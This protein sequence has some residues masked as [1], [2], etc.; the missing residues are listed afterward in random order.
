MRKI[1]PINEKPSITTCIH[2][3]YPCAII[4][5]KMLA[6]ISVSQF[7]KSEW[8]ILTRDTSV[9]VEADHIIVYEN[10]KGDDTNTV[11]WRH[12][13][14]CDECIVNMEYVKPKDIGRY[15][16]V[17]LFDDNMENEIRLKDKT[18]GIRWNPYGYFVVE[19]MYNFD[20]KIYTFL[21]IC[22]N[23]KQ[24]K[25]YASK[26]GIKW[27]FIIQKAIP[28]NFKA[29][30]LH[31][32]IHMFLGIDFFTLWKNMNFIQLIYN[33]E[34][35][36][37]GIDLDYYFFPRKNVDNSYMYF[38]NF[39]DTYYDI[40]YDVLDC[41]PTIHEYIRWNIQHMFYPEICLDE[42][43][44]P[45][46][47]S[48]DETHYK[49]YS[50]F[51]GFDDERKKYFI[52]GYGKNSKPVISELPYDALSNDIIRSEKIVRYKFCSNDVTNLRF[53]IN[54]VKLGL[55]EYINSIDSSE[56]S[57]NLLTEE[58]LVYGVSILKILANDK[59]AR[60]KIRDDQ[61][62]SFCILEHSKL[63]KERIRFLY[64]KK[65]LQEIG[66]V[67]LKARCDEIIRIASMIM[68]LVLKNAISSI[69]TD[70]LDK[71]LLLLHDLEKD[72][73]Q[74]LLDELNNVKS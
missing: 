39:L 27:E 24:I 18:C 31:I 29:D 52:M 4:E 19:E 6:D 1:L 36:W 42:F 22:V 50:L 11:I 3:A 35:E 57:A 74:N 12:C 43:Y 67:K 63:M 44:V 62:I 25:G 55:Y 72:F 21:K 64:E 37:K 51:Y 14:P 60:F 49:H 20:T 8:N 9:S 53:N 15:I 32:G 65:Y 47:S 59:R 16:D 68:A 7:A 71:Y 61:R 56:K 33:H 2:Y 10:E 38:P 54:A 70:R 69:N 28:G 46:R 58:P 34:N 41:F 45:G 23:N 48:Y 73:C 13:K 17:F 40:L 26:D 30:N 5:S 66:Y